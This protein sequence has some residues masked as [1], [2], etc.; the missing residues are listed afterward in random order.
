MGLDNKQRR[1]R[2]DK[3]EVGNEYKYFIRFGHNIFIRM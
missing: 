1:K 2:V 3:A